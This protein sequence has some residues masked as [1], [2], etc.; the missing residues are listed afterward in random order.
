MIRYL[1]D[2]DPFPSEMK[3]IRPLK[4]ESHCESEQGASSYLLPVDDPAEDILLDL[5]KLISFLK[6]GGRGQVQEIF[7]DTLVL[8]FKVSVLLL[9]PLL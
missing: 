1:C 5:D 6:V 7:K 8:A 3:M 4:I 2:L 9:V